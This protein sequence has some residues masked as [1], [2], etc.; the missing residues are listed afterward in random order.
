MSGSHTER[1]RDYARRGN[2]ALT[3][4]PWNGEDREDTLSC[5]VEAFFL[6]HAP[7]TNCQD[8]SPLGQT[9]NR[10]SVGSHE[11][12]VHRPSLRSSPQGFRCEFP[13]AS[14]R[15]RPAGVVAGGEGG[16]LLYNRLTYNEVAR[17]LHRKPS[18]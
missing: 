15:L 18:T 13:V 16:G 11:S 12:T 10:S 6:L 14:L 5:G 4:L 17:G 1:T 2:A 3:P 9:F 8:N 7:A